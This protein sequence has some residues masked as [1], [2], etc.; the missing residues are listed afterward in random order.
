MVHVQTDACLA[1]TQTHTMCVL[2]P[3]QT[4]SDGLG[5]SLI[6]KEK[7]RPQGPVRARVCVEVL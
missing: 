6:N 1:L 4:A 2:H 7:T 3:S 5:R